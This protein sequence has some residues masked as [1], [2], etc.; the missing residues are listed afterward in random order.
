M[1][2]EENRMY[3]NAIA[4]TTSYQDST[5]ENGSTKT[6]Y[7][8]GITDAA[9]I[10]T[11]PKKNR[12]SGSIEFDEIFEVAK[13]KNSHE[14]LDLILNLA[15]KMEHLLYLDVTERMQLFDVEFIKPIFACFL[16]HCNGNSDTF[17]SLHP[18]F[19]HSKF[20]KGCGAAK[21]DC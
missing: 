21:V 9:T 11:A 5:K 14:K 10:P 17:H 13:T 8:I 2:N 20:S 7:A 4:A 1:K 12:K 19:L 18:Q 3:S 16:N 15:S 6:V